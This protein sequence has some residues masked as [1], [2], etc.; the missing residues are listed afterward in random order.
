MVLVSA[1][2]RGHVML[3]GFVIVLDMN[4]IGRAVLG[5]GFLDCSTRILACVVALRLG[6]RRIVLRVVLRGRFLAE[7]HRHAF[8]PVPSL[9]R[10][11][12][13]FVASSKGQNPIHHYL[14][15]VRSAAL[16]PS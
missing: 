5:N 12:L 2:M 16:V 15:R 3:A 10:A 1:V 6:L 13:G 11:I 8:S 4:L 7:E 9:V 14:A